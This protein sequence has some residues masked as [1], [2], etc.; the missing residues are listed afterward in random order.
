MAEL[1]ELGD[2]LTNALPFT[3]V[4]IDSLLGEMQSQAP[5]EPRDKA[6]E[7]DDE[8]FSINA[9]LPMTFYETWANAIETVRGQVDRLHDDP[10]V[11]AGQVIEVLT[12]EFLASS[13][14][15]SQS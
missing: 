3:A 9:R 1:Q 6:G 2:D 14:A 12:A 15:G 11:Q 7:P 4:D 13:Y 8:W 5:G 10:K